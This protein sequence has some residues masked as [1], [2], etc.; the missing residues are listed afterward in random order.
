MSLQTYGSSCNSSCVSLKFNCVSQYITLL[1]VAR[2]N[3][4]SSA[5]NSLA[6]SAA[7]TASFPT[8]VTF[9]EEGQHLRAYPSNDSDSSGNVDS[10]D[11][12]LHFQPNSEIHAKNWRPQLLTIMDVDYHGNP[13]NGHLMSVA[14]QL[15]HTGK[16]INVVISIIDRSQASK[17]ASVASGV[18]DICAEASA[19]DASILSEITG[20]SCL[21]PAQSP[22][23]GRW[24]N[25]EESQSL[26]RGIDHFDT[27][28]LIQ[29][30]K[31][32]LMFQMKVEGMTGFAECSTTDG[33]FFEAV[34]SA[35]IHTGLG[36]LSPNTIL[37]S[38]PSFLA[39]EE[40]SSRNTD[41]SMK[42]SIAYE[43][44]KIR[45]EEYLRTIN[46]ILNLGKAVI[47]FKGCQN[48]P[49][50]SALMPERGTIDVWWIVHDGGLL[51]LL[52]FLL[53]RHPVWA[54]IN[55]ENGMKKKDRRHRLRLGAK[56]RLFAAVTNRKENPEKLHDAVVDHLERVRI[57]AEV[58]VVDLA[59]TDIAEYMRDR[60]DVAPRLDLSTKSRNPIASLRKDGINTHNMT[61]G[62][63]F[64]SEAREECVPS[65]EQEQSSPSNDVSNQINDSSSPIDTASMLNGAMRRYSGD[66]NLVA[67]NL[68]FIRKNQC[69]ETYF[70]FVNKACHGIDNVMLVRGSGAEVIT[71]Y[72]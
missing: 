55:K 40:D 70:E 56:L 39:F 58:T 43:Q 16:G 17:A 64:A 4:I 19:E 51:L 41:N 32:L 23:M 47:L 15:Q 62:E 27:I 54:G 49:S 65:K 22:T 57:Q 9:S 35:V 33:Q 48:Y 69:A 36:P 50:N 45:A 31:A 29:R 10:K 26:S 52:P 66:A 38:L 42:N 44:D 6:K 34:S 68:P 14:A 12:W 67:V 20:A 13:T 46:A 21:A 24:Q 1:C 71:A 37:L 11:E 3:I 60:N 8:E 7:S 63:V 30:S 53:S 61:L 59:G 2:Y 5:L 18:D 25:E 28:K 72:A